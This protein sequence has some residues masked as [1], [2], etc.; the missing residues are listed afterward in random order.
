[1]YFSLMMVCDNGVDHHHAV[2]Y[3]G[4]DPDFVCIV[5]TRIQIVTLMSSVYALLYVLHSRK[6]SR[7]PSSSR[8]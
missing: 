7:R 5:C 3:H 6:S 2:P 1:M 4:P 8:E